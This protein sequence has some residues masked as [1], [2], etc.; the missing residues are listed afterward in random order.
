MIKKSKRIIPKKS[1]KY[2]NNK[3]L[4]LDEYYFSLYLD[5]LKSNGFILSYQYEP[6]A[7]NLRDA[8]TVSNTIN[9]T[10]EN[11]K[12]LKPKIENT[13]MFSN[14]G[15][16]CDFKIKWNILK[17]DGIFTKTENKVYNKSVKNIPFLL[18][19][20]QDISYIEV[21]PEFDQNNM[22][23]YVKVKI[24][25]VHQL[26]NTYVQIVNYESLFKKTFYPDLYFYTLTGKD[27][28]KKTKDG[29]SILLKDSIKYNSID[30]YLLSLHSN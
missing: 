15:Y 9:K 24:A 26:F 10:G 3:Y 25:W 2:I 27:K 14:L 8:M 4:S 1:I 13:K 6:P 20:H 17:S 18:Q 16:T 22:T 21:K 23:R 11:N 5:E 19:E 28:V 12:I 7:F 30:Q 29:K